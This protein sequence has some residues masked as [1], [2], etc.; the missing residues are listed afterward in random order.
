VPVPEEGVFS[1]VRRLG[2]APAIVDREVIEAI[3]AGRI[4][5][6]AGV[7]SFDGAHVL[8]ADGARGK[9]DVV[10]CATGYRRGLEALVGRLDVLDVRGVP[11]ALGPEPAAP[12]LRFVGYVPRPGGLGYM[13]KEAKRTAKAIAREIR[14]PRAVSRREL[15]LRS[16]LG[17]IVWTGGPGRLVGTDVAMRLRLFPQVAAEQDRIAGSQ[18]GDDRLTAEALL[19]WRHPLADVLRRTELASKS[20]LFACGARPNR[21][22]EAAGSSPASSIE[23][24]AN[25]V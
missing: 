19:G 12:G 24:P 10:I 20:P 22:Q 13:A 5:V 18:A 3:K 23:I 14:A 11:R 2:Q 9:P 4:E 7:E 25:R 16:P 17:G 1:R 15:W 8:L 21:T 6:V